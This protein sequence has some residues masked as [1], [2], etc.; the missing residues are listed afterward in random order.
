VLADLTKDHL[1]ELRVLAPA[2]V[3]TLHTVLPSP[4]RRKTVSERSRGRA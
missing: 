1:D 2:L 3:A 4:R